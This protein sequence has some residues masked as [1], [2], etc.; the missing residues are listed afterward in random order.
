LSFQNVANQLHPSVLLRGSPVEDERSM[1]SV[2]TTLFHRSKKKNVFEFERVDQL[3]PFLCENFD[4]NP[5][6][7]PANLFLVE[8][9]A[10]FNLTWE[11]GEVC[12]KFVKMFRH[13]LVPSEKLFFA[14]L[15][16]HK[17]DSTHKTLNNLFLILLEANLLIGFESRNKVLH[18]CIAQGSVDK[19]RAFLEVLVDVEVQDW[20]FEVALIYGRHKTIQVLLRKTK[21]TRNPF[22]L[23][24]YETSKH[25]PNFEI[26]GCSFLVENYIT[27]N[28]I[29]EDNIN[30]TRCLEILEEVGITIRDDDEA[31]FRWLDITLPAFDGP[32]GVYYP[33]WSTVYHAFLGQGLNNG[34]NP[35]RLVSCLRSRNVSRSVI[36]NI[37]IKFYGESIIDYLV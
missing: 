30:P 27:R 1:V 20:M 28:V 31:L 2:I 36:F 26:Y 13:R 35:S 3:D 10:R 19:V 34:L 18:R 22:L 6:K 33:H 4:E 15:D 29:N 25:D 14:V 32:M 21:P 17:S 9:L 8:M 37:L 7:N 11:T 24:F 23:Q 16:T 12:L 5:E